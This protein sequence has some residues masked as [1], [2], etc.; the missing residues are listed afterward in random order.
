MTILEFLALVVVAGVCGSLGQA[1]SGYTRGGCLASV[2]LG[3]VG[4]LLGLW[5][6]RLVGLPEILT[7]QI[8]GTGFPLVWSVFGSALFVAFLS[9]LHGRRRT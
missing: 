7:V 2:A 4:A 6:A 8:G 1:L 3:F 9:V 5:I